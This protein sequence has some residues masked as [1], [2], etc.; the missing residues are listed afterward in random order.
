MDDN[1]KNAYRHLLYVAMLD[2]RLYCQSRGQ[3]SWN[4]LEWYR[5]YRQ[6]RVA[7]VLADW[8][9]NLADYS[10]QEFNGFDEQR[11]WE[12]HTGLCNRFSGKLEH[13]RKIF[14]LYL[15]GDKFMC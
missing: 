12:E 13:Y 2:I 8:L 7:G 1:T 14:D 15:I 5:Q 6:S 11:F 10:S 9:H 3:F 4:P